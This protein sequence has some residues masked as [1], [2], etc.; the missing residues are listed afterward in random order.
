M[1][2]NSI[3]IWKYLRK[4]GC[5]KAG[6]A[7]LMGNMQHESGLIPNR[8]EDL[9]RR[10]I[11]ETYGISYTDEQYTAEVDSGKI[12]RGS[13]A[14]ND[15]GNT[16]LH[17]LAGKQ[18]GYGLTQLTYPSRKAGLYDLCKKKGKSIGDL[19]C[20]LAWLITELKTSFKS[21]WN[22]V[23]ESTDVNTCTDTVLTKFEIPANPEA[24]K[25]ARR[26][27]AWDFYYK[28]QNE[29]IGMPTPAAQ[30]AAAA[31]SEVKVGKSMYT[32]ESAKQAIIKRATAEIGY[33]E[34]RSN[35]NLDSKTL[36]AGSA[37]YTK[38]A[39]DVAPLSWAQAQPWCCTFYNW[40]F[41]QE[42]GAEK[43]K[44]M[45]NGYT[46]SCYQAM[47]NYKAKGRWGKTPHVGDQIIFRNGQHTGLVVAVAAGTITTIEGNTSGAS[48][49][50]PNGGGVRK[51][52]YNRSYYAITGYGTPDWS[53]VA[54]TASKPNTPAPTAPAEPAKPA[55]GAPSK[56][57]KFHGVCTG[58]E[59]AVRTWA[60][61]ENPQLKSIPSL[62]KGDQVDVCDTV[63]SKA[64][65][66]WYYVCIHGNIYGFMYAKYIQKV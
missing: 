10:P 35:K 12:K 56:K 34:K 25:A 44:K 20:Q 3:Q 30:T 8:L 58:D 45:L 42:F 47:M 50:V 17:P 51:K 15:G 19:E 13:E 6:A 64:G 40:L 22:V 46:A 29:A 27:S 53:L 48:G 31:V 61:T 7:G 37:N 14:G 65:K 11:K 62:N 49:V 60:G 24:L 16:F 1:E 4:A 63:K 41:Y 9:C 5:T 55:A 43:G 57:T 2:D 28:Y 18:Y 26:K 38:Y 21:V 23:S 54:E 32:E 59:V 52:S 36:N 66:N 33:L 39:R